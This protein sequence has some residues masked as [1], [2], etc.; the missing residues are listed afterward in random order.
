MIFLLHFPL[1]PLPMEKSFF[2]CSTT[3]HAEIGE[4]TRFE[5]LNGVLS[6][7]FFDNNASLCRRSRDKLVQFPAVQ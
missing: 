7:F 6:S 2:I 5:I 4:R 1:N 3:L